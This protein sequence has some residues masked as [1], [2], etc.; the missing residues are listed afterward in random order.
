MI[1]V[2]FKSIE[3]GD[4]CCINAFF[5]CDVSVEEIGRDEFDHEPETNFSEITFDKV[6]Y[7]DEEIKIIEEY[8]S[9]NEES[10][11]G[12]FWEEYLTL[13]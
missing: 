7:S 9:E 12:E 13:I 8:I 1:V 4:D 6:V 3:S 11:R 10:L 2:L 5:F